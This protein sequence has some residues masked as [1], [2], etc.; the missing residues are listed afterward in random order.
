MDLASCLFEFL[1]A[2]GGIIA[3]LL[4]GYLNESFK[5]EAT[6]DLFGCGIIA[7]LM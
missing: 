2:L 5:Y 7:T 1:L 3:P 6:T 4:G